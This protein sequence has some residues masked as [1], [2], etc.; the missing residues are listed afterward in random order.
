[1][2]GTPAHPAL[3]GRL[4]RSWAE[5]AG[6]VAD[7]RGH[8]AGA[9]VPPLVGDRVWDAGRNP[10]AWTVDEPDGG[11]RT[12]RML[13]LVRW[14]CGTGP[15]P[16]AL[17]E[18]PTVDA[19]PLTDAVILWRW[20]QR[21]V[22]HEGSERAATWWATVAGTVGA[23]HRSVRTRGR[24]TPV[25]EEATRRLVAPGGPW[26]PPGGLLGPLLDRIR[27]GP[28]P[29]GADPG[30]LGWLAALASAVDGEVHI[31]SS[32]PDGTL[33]VRTGARDVEVPPG[34][35]ETTSPLLAARMRTALVDATWDGR[36]RRMDLEPA[37]ARL[38]PVAGLV[39]PAARRHWSTDRD[40]WGDM[41]PFGRLCA[42]LWG[43]DDPTVLAVTAVSPATPVPTL[44]VRRFTLSVIRSPDPPSTLANLEML[45]VRWWSKALRG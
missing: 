7:L 12:G 8:P 29:Q 43:W 34:V 26:P 42:V 18:V 15:G 37:L 21:M 35:W 31:R 32:Q 45:W 17:R 11:D 44:L 20:P 25:M 40:L 36:P 4:R 1:M 19:G 5:A 33:V 24:W 6:T 38:T 14:L 10:L 13:R 22:D 41:T 9:P 39:D 28:P 16:G 23:P 30:R 2:S 3:L 27:G